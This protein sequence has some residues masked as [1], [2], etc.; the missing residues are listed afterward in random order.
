MRHSPRAST[1]GA[2]TLVEVIVAMVLSIII[3]GVC[4]TIMV[5]TLA[6]GRRTRTQ[7]EMARDGSFTGQ[8]FAQELRQAGL[9]VPNGGHINAANGTTT[10]VAF[11]A[12]LLVA[13]PTQI[14]IVGDLA[15]PDANYNAYG[16][17]HNRT[18]GS[19]DVAWHT[20]N[21]GTCVVDA[22]S[23]SCSTAVSSLF[24]P[25]EA[26]CDAAG[27]G[28][29]GDRTCP[30]GLRRVLPGERLIIVSG[31]G[32]WAHAALATPGTVD[33]AGPLQVLAARLSP[34]YSPADW[35]DP[36][37]PSLPV[38]VPNETAGQGWV[39]T[40][41]RVFFTFDAATHTIQR[42][43][44]S[45]DPDPENPN[46]P[47]PTAT[48]IPASAVFTPTGG[49]PNV[50]G[51][52]EIIARHVDSLAFSYFDAAGAPVL[53]RNTGPLKKSIR[54]VNYRIQFRHTLDGRDV[55]YDVAGSVRLQNL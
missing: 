33:N 29:F 10:N 22:V 27:T 41:D 42:M 1:P 11:Y 7:A 2:F 47:G 16:P 28:H 48:A 8:L 30:W 34:G 53:L 4:M 18:V 36:V 5:N 50:C 24:F 44:C 26:G 43:Q 38:T 17:L 14:G 55:T 19:A 49:A 12:S 39:T 46:W 25:G 45:G 21:N 32:R 54:R 6:E 3:L 37:A 15:R 35:P 52:F 13:A 51:P 9:G 23:G 40:L 31:D 20:E